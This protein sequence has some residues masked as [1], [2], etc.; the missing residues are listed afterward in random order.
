[1]NRIDER[2][3]AFWISKLGVD[4]LTELQGKSTDGS[5]F[6]KALRIVRQ[7]GEDHERFHDLIWEGLD[8]YFHQSVHTRT[9]GRKSLSGPLAKLSVGKSQGEIEWWSRQSLP[10]RKGIRVLCGAR[11]RME[12]LTETDQIV[13]HVVT[14]PVMVEALSSRL[15]IRVVTLQSTATTWTDLM[16]VPVRRILTPV[17]ENELADLLLNI[18]A[19]IEPGLGQ[20]QDLSAR[21]VELMK[22]VDKV[23]TYSGTYGVRTVGRTQ[24]RSEGGRRGSH[25]QP[26]HVVMQPEFGELTSAEKIRHCE[27]EI[28]KE[29]NGLPRGTAVV[30]YPTEGK[31]I[32]RRMLGG[33]VIN[34]FLA[35]MA[36]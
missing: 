28:Q 34:D 23:Y 6:E 5:P 33:G 26:L 25:R 8:G 27:I 15:R 14:V 10:S 22:D 18:L 2:L 16:G 30:I 31:I 21:S 35:Y 7:I 11:K 29:W 20:M 13:R 4:R 19:Q 1:M 17:T 36:S 9:L 12:F 3:N 32:F 24:H